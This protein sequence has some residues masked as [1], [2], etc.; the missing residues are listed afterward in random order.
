ML[1][2]EEKERE[3]RFKLAL[4]MGLPI[5][6]LTLLLAL[7]WL[8][9]YYHPIPLSFFVTAFIILGIMIYFIFYL[10]Y[11]GFDERITDPITRTFTR[12]Y[13]LSAFKKE[14]ASSPY[15]IIL[16]SID[17]LHDI[18]QR[19]STVNGDKVLKQFAIWINGFLQEKGI[20]KVPIG[21]FKGGDFL[22][23]LKGK[24]SQ[25]TTLM[26][27]LCIKIENKMVDDIEIH[28]SSAIID[29]TLTNDIDQLI[30]R[31]FELKQE[32]KAQ[33]Q[34][35]MEDEEINPSELELSVIHAVKEKKFSM[36]FQ[37]VTEQGSTVIVESSIK[38][39]S[40]ENKLIHQKSYIPVV[41]RLGLSREFDTLILEYLIDLC[42]K[43]DNSLI[44]ALTL[45]PSTVRNHAFVEKAHILLSNNTAAKGRILFILG[46]QEYYSH[47]ARYNDVL[48]SYRRMGV[49]IT[50]DRLG[51]YQTT[52][53]YLKEL[54]ID[55]IRFDLHYGKKIT[56]RGYQSILRGLNYSAHYLGVKTWIRMIENDE[57]KS[58]A[59]SIGIDYIQG[60]IIGKIVSI[61]EIN[62]EIR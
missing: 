14:I 47:T 13:L 20:E 7:I 31:L 44:F 40:R 42:C 45:F 32:V 60:N 56:D 2:S 12:E 53:L 24:K 48:Q 38:L 51:I 6:S 26:E 18:N 35:L 5:F 61:E 57:A 30:T 29:T 62:S 54:H 10:I 3:I 23:G 39:Y 22:I 27:L 52:L 25:Y 43:S 4:R 41:N 8:S 37:K 9:K 28:I 36:L 16:V 50:L 1:Y 58:I 49:L 59:E 11:K 34:D 55:I 46:E 19:Y 21:H 17:N 15:T 33:K